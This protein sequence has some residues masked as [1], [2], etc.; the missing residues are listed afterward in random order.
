MVAKMSR[1][2][3]GKHGVEEYLAIGLGNAMTFQPAIND[4]EVLDLDRETRR[5][6]ATLLPFSR[7]LLSNGDVFQRFEFAGTNF[8]GRDACFTSD[9]V[10]AWL[11][12][13]KSPSTA[14][15]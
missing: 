8:D 12:S 1:E 4:D 11:C 14:K 15:H 5:F 10:S 7:R 2:V 3:D 6:T 13:D 9:S